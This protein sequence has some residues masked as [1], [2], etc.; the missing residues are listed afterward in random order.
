MSTFKNLFTNPLKPSL[1]DFSNPGTVLEQIPVPGRLTLDY[2]PET[3]GFTFKPTGDFPRRVTEGDALAYA[4]DFP[5]PAPLSGLVLLDEER[6]VFQIKM[7]GSFRVGAGAGPDRG[8]SKELEQA[9]PG[10]ALTLLQ[11]KIRDA[12]IPSLDFKSRPLFKM[13]ERALSHKRPRIILSRVDPEGL[14]D[15]EKVFASRKRDVGA[16]LAL[17]DRVLKQSGQKDYRLYNFPKSFDPLR[18]RASMANYGLN[19]PEKIALEI[20]PA[21][22]RPEVRTSLEEQGILF[23]GPATLWALFNLINE[24]TPFT[25]RV[26]ALAFQKKARRQLKT[27]VKDT[28]L[29]NIPNG[30]NLGDIFSSIYQAQDNGKREKVRI[31]QGD[32]FRHA[33]LTPAELEEPFFCG[34]RPAYFHFLKNDRALYGASP[35]F[36]CNGCLACQNICPVNAAP[37]SLVEGNRSEFNLKDCLLCGLCE[38]SCDSGIPI[39]EA[40]KKEKERANPAL[41]PREVW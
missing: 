27:R 22:E 1:P 33:P 15:W 25:G 24:Q 28:A 34:Y 35:N 7:E 9:K 41:K 14:V 23:I 36:P 31:V 4:D 17:F 12:G 40:I 2:S 8:L 26:V 38:Y 39:T 20:L 3:T 37:L 13:F 19:L 32:I 18:S 6:K 29:Y 5:M 11:Q 16:L 10:E 21:D 30:Y